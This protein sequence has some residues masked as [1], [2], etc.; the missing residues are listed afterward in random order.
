MVEPAS[1]FGL[2][3]S[4]SNVSIPLTGVNYDFSIKSFAGHITI[5]Q[6]YKNTEATDLEC[7]YGFPISDQASIVGLT[8]EIDNRTLTSAFKK[9]DEAFKEYTEALKRN[10]GAYLL[11]QSE[12]S[13]DTFVLSVGRLPPGKECKVSISYVT[14]LESVTETKSRLT[15]PTSLYPRYDPTPKLQKTG[16]VAPE[17]FQSTVPYKAT[18]SGHIQAVDTIENIT[19][20]THPLL[21]STVGPKEAS[22]TFNG[23]Q[24]A[25]DKDLVIEVELKKNPQSYVEVEETSPGVYTA[26]YAFVPSFKPDN[27]GINSELIFVVDCS[28][29]MSGGNKIGDA[30]R[31]MHIFLRSIPEGAYFNFY[32][33]GSRFESLFPESQLYSADTFTQAKAYADAINADMGGTEIL[34]PLQKIYTSAPMTKFVG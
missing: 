19:S 31:A 21:V 22:V 3:V 18:L 34:E 8:I 33:F 15:I 26:M 16:V 12:R 4:L 10:D 9:K 23:T 28:G 5:D 7:V 11:D 25:L 20:P 6:T 13:D 32:K 24:Q 17:T 14:T 29:S 2:F 27:S 1:L 30:K